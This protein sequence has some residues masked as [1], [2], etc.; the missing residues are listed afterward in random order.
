MV[1]VVKTASFVFALF[2]LYSKITALLALE[3][4]NAV[5]FVTLRI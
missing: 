3:W 1:C 5:A 4:I 2:S